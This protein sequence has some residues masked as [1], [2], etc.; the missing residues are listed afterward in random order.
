VLGVPSNLDQYLAMTAI[1]QA[2]AGRLLRAGGLRAERVRDAAKELIESAALSEG[3]RRVAQ[4]FAR[5][6]CH[7]RFAQ[8]LEQSFQKGLA[9]ASS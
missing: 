8:V 3:A 2:G 7:Q 6:D 9:H 1:E 4:A 5:F